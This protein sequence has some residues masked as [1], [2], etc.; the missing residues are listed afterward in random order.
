MFPVKCRADQT[1]KCYII[2]GFFNVQG[3]QLY[4]SLSY[5]SPNNASSVDS[6]VLIFIHL[7]PVSFL[8][9]IFKQSRLKHFQSIKMSSF[10]WQLLNPFCFLQLGTGWPY[11]VCFGFF[12]FV[13]IR[14]KKIIPVLENQWT[15]LSSGCCWILYTT[16]SILNRNVIF[17][18]LWNLFMIAPWNVCWGSNPMLPPCHR[19]TLWSLWLCKL[20]GLTEA[21]F[22]RKSVYWWFP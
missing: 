16:S 2:F 19:G 21:I 7:L 14:R 17:Q 8:T 5:F 4:H 10:I 22:Q 13:Q 18:V 15:A 12:L 20:K 6:L 3:A 1:F 11:P 9:S